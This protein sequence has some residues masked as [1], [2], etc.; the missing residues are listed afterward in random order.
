MSLAALMD[1]WQM[2]RGFLLELISKELG[3]DAQL[4]DLAN[5]TSGGARDG[6]KL[7]GGHRDRTDRRYCTTVA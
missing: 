7:F 1:R 3:S 5:L 4:A 2:S 6:L